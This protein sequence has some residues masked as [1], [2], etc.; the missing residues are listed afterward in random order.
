M[1]VARGAYGFRL[2]GV[3]RAHSLLVDVRP[4]CPALEI[5]CRPITGPGP[6]ADRVSEERVELRLQTGGWVELDRMPARAAF[7]LQ[8]RPD[9]GALVHPYL[10]PVA[11]M[12]AR[13]LGRDS[14]HAGAVIV[15]GGAWALVGD[16][17]S[18]KSSTLAHLALSGYD[19]LTDDMLIVQDGEALPGPRCVDLRPGPAAQLGV[20]TPLGVIGQRERW[21]ME[22]GPLAASRL[23]LRGWVK[24][25]WDDRTEVRQVRGAQRLAGIE[26]HRAVRL[27][28]RDPRG[29]LDLSALPLLELRRPQRWEALPEA[30]DRLLGAIAG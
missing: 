4:G 28:P 26:Q 21:R 27:P 16:K 6:P 14:F 20:G 2:I 30:A 18:G 22:L 25:D 11:A 9:D 5:V 12:A 13:W 8:A 17:G 19:V 7:H 10:A 24:L 29:L 15:D 3:E 23:P 1:R